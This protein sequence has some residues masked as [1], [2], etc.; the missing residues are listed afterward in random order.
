[1]VN[2]TQTFGGIMSIH[3]SLKRNEWDGNRTV[4]SRL[5]RIKLLIEQ[6]KWKDEKIFSLPKVK[7]V[8]LKK[9]KLEK[10]EKE[11][12]TNWDDIKK[13]KK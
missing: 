10:I 13:E 12:T 5:E 6:G 8:K 3:K 1:M 4:L 2:K 9:I 11:E 7:I